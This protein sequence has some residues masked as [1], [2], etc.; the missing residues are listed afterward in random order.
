[1]LRCTVS[2]VGITLVS[3]HTKAM[4]T[5]IERSS[6]RHMVM[7]HFLIHKVGFSLLV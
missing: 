3:F 2:E 5:A 1:M 4:E 6:V 7:G